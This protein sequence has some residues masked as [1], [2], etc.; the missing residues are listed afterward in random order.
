MDNSLQK[1]RAQG[2]SRRPKHRPSAT[3]RYTQ[4]QGK[5]Y[6][7]LISEKPLNAKSI[8]AK[9]IAKIAASLSFKPLKTAIYSVYHDTAGQHHYHPLMLHWDGKK[10]HIMPKLNT[11]LMAEKDYLDVLLTYSTK[12]GNQSKKH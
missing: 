2:Q 11:N 5:N 3:I 4:M 9:T 10:I 7:F 1:N 6:L 12:L 8:N